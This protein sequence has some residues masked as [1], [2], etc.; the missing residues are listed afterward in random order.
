M[1]DSLFSTMEQLFETDAL[2]AAPM[3]SLDACLLNL[4]NPGLN[5]TTRL[6]PHL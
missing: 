1:M 2:S 6:A 3:I 5:S 4:Y